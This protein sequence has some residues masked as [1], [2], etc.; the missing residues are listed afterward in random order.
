MP[1][2]HP[3]ASTMFHVVDH[4][5]AHLSREVVLDRNRHQLGTHHT[6]RIDYAAYRAKK[7][8]LLGQ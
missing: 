8:R 2:A 6:K 5:P 3:I 4:Q 7:N 1:L